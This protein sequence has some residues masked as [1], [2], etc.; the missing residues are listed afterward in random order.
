MLLN[1]SLVILFFFSVLEDIVCCFSPGGRK[2][3][4]TEKCQ[5]PI[6][7]IKQLNNKKKSIAGWQ[8]FMIGSP[9]T[10]LHPLSGYASDLHTLKLARR[11]QQTPPGWDLA[12][13]SL[14]PARSFSFY[15][16]DYSHS[17]GC[18]LLIINH[19]W[20]LCTTCSGSNHLYSLSCCNL[21]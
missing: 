7:N 21:A 17:F 8:W 6:S 12:A 5:K 4:L 16:P 20:H 11:R 14:L 18:S 15:L 1:L 9:I 10:L 13:N 3:K 2:K 19:A